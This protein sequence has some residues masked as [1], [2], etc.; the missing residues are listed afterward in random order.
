M[1]WWRDIFPG[2]STGMLTSLVRTSM[3][4]ALVTPSRCLRVA[5]STPRVGSGR[6]TSRGRAA[7]APTWR[8]SWWSA[9]PPWPAM[10]P[11]PTSAGTG[12]GS[13]QNRLLLRLFVTLLASIQRNYEIMIFFSELIQ[14]IWRNYKGFGIE[15]KKYIEITISNIIDNPAN[16]YLKMYKKYC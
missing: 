9:T 16:N 1:M 15:N 12:E 3:A 11:P 6:P 2:S 13:G 10:A 7:G 14:R 4:G 8:W 5:H